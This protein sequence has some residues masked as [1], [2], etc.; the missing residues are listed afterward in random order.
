[1]EIQSDGQMGWH[2][3]AE[4]WHGTYAAEDGVIHAQLTPDSGQSPQLWDFHI[5]AETKR[6][7][8]KWPIG[9]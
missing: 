7:G 2:I 9:T 8:W 3:G 5:A 4:G 1:M 6:Q